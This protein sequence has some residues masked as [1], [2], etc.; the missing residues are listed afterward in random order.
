MRRSTLPGCAAGNLCE[1]PQMITVTAGGAPEIS[2]V[3]PN[4]VNAGGALTIIG[5]AF[6]EPQGNSVVTIGGANAAVQSWGNNQIVVQV[7]TGASGDVQ[8]VAVVD[9]E[10]S[11]SV[12]L[13]VLGTGDV[14]V[15]L[16]WSDLND[17]DLHV[18][19]PTGATI[20]YINTTSASGGRLDVDANPGCTSPTASPRENIFWAGQ[21]PTGSYQVSVVYFRGCPSGQ[22]EMPS[23]GVSV[24]V[25]KGGEVTTLIN[26]ATVGPGGT[27][28]ASFMR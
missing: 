21:A 3:G 26:K 11:N 5:Q 15:T 23:S 7:P 6:G 20:N 24:T 2:S 16:S 9:G 8:V 1:Q 12:P 27:L 17:L 4:P 25:R 14:Q 28:N 10:S 22:P 19:D 18:T 13:K